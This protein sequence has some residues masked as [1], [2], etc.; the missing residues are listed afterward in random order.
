M[1]L[2]ESVVQ[3]TES[4]EEKCLLLLIHVVEGLDVL[5]SLGATLGDGFGLAEEFA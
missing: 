4:L 1:F 5:G 3:S 2:V